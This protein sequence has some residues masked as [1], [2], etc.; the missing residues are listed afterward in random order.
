MWVR[1]AYEA[2]LKGTPRP[3]SAERWY[4]IQERRLREFGGDEGEG[5]VT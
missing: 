5:R 3:R 1:R 4:M 2:M